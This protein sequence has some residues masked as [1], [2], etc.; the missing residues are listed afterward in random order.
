MLSCAAMK[1][2]RFIILTAAVLAVAS[3]SASAQSKIA[4]VDMKKI[5]NGYW[6]THEAQTL[7]EKSQA[8]LRKDLKDMADGLDKAQVD[9]K[10]LL[11]QA[12]DQAISADER[13]KRKTAATDKAKEINNQKAAFDQYQRQAGS[14]LQEKTQRMSASLVTDIQKAVS[15][16]AKAGGYTVV[17]NSATTEA[18]VYT[19]SSIDLTDAV[20]K[21]LNAGA[22]IDVSRPSSGVPFNISTNLP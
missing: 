4:A 17:L 1:N 22:P 20:L 8:D 19:D 3:L 21:Q 10:K 14:S 2:L 16:K 12:N 11:E 13:E 15:D 5:F 6:K 7:V 9:Y 18:I